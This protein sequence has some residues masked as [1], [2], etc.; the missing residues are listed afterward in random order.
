[1]YSRILQRLAL[2]LFIACCYGCSGGNAD[3]RVAEDWMAR[4]KSQWPQIVLTNDAQFAGHSPLVGA[5]AFLIRTSDDRVLAATAK[6]LIGSAG[7]VEPE[8]PVDLLPEK[9]VSWRVHPRTL[10]IDFVEIAALGAQGLDDDDHDWLVLSLKPH[11]HVPSR[12]LKMRQH[13]VAVG[14]TVFLIGCS[15]QEPEC[16]QSVYT[17]VVT[18]RAFGD[19]FRYDITPQVD[20]RRIQRRTDHR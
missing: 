8:I 2:A 17:G 20:I 18:E 4:R 11:R 19:R 9:I 16:K 14:E 5:S 3:N 10:P 7:G 12:A 13:P 6:H 15:Y 1:M